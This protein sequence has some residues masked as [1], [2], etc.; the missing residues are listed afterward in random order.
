MSFVAR[1][2]VSFLNITH[3]VT[4]EK[5]KL[6]GKRQKVNSNRGFCKQ[7]GLESSS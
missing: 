3:K 4:S 2:H 5:R 7:F 6:N 1:K